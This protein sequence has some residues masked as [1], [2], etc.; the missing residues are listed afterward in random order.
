MSDR[1]KRRKRWFEV[2]SDFERIEKML[3]K[4]V[5]ET[6]SPKASSDSFLTKKKEVTNPRIFI[7]SFSKGPDGKPV[8]R[9]FGNLHGGCLEP[10]IQRSREPLIDV[11]E[12]DDEVRVIVDLPGIKDS[13][14]DLRALESKLIISV[15]AP[16]RKYYKEIQLPKRVDPKT[17][18]ASYRN[19]VLDVRLKA[20]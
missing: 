18:I 10:Q 7:F 16:N 19:G 4:M 20:R 17:S 8:I 5:G 1:G 14:I 9:A 12:E 15:G 2:F 11:F 6:K 3:D 13:D